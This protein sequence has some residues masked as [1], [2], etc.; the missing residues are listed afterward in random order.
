M[1]E[2]ADIAQTTPESQR[3][4]VSPVRCLTRAVTVSGGIAALIS[5]AIASG[6]GA[7]EPA[8]YASFTV[9]ASAIAGL[10]M[11]AA[12]GTKPRAA[13]GFPVLGAQMIRMMLA[14]AA[15]LVVHFAAGLS[16]GDEALAFWLTLLAVAAAMLAAETIA[17][18]RM[19]GASP[20]T[21]VATGREAVA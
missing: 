13:W 11:L 7:A 2:S 6:F 17:A 20:S 1:T 18:A 10:G 16:T 14:P 3:D 15:G 9:F 19:L 4:L 5:V 8:A 21:G 12:L